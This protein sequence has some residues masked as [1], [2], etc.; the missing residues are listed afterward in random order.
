VSCCLT[1]CTRCYFHYAKL[2]C[3]ICCCS[4]NNLLCLLSNWL[5]HYVI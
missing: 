3:L 2:L 5:F 4:V 1:F